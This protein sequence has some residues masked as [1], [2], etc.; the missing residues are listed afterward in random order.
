MTA[1]WT[2]LL[3]LAA[4][5][6]L[7]AAA[8]KTLDTLNTLQTSQDFKV[9]ALLDT[10][11]QGTRFF[12]IANGTR[13]D[14]TQHV[15][16]LYPPAGGND[17]ADPATLTKFLDWSHDEYPAERVA[18][19][20]WNHGGGVK[21]LPFDDDAN[22]PVLRRAA[23]RAQRFRL[24]AE[25]VPFKRQRVA[26]D[27]AEEPL[28]DAI[29]LNFHSKEYL[30]NFEFR[31]AF[32]NSKLKSVDVLVCHA[33]LMS[34]LEICYEMRDTYG[35]FVA[36]EAL[37]NEFDLPF[38]AIL[39]ELA[40]NL[41]RD[42][43]QLAKSFVDHFQKANDDGTKH[44]TFAAVS[45]AGVE[46]LATRY[47]AFANRLSKLPKDPIRTARALQMRGLHIPDYID[48]RSVLKVL[49]KTFAGDPLEPLA[50]KARAAL[51]DAFVARACFGQEDEDKCGMSI[52]FP[53]ESGARAFLV[54]YKKLQF[55]IDKPSWHTFLDAFL[56]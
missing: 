49:G 19:V 55:G 42:D 56:A 38:A 26:P 54:D 44:G 20:V 52:F 41:T 30:D 39:A 28:S 36:S 40:N 25:V 17:A 34:M 14:K 11:D 13:A 2:V 6:D 23:R 29:G 31:Q 9:L 18:V 7:A 22:Q 15:D 50:T 33:C 27:S 53:N 16:A 48:L 37:M 10:K 4:D 43:K 12:E 45:R 1:K 51:E 8:E 21:D 46:E 5:N 3:Y 47:E 35:C 32:D 24:S